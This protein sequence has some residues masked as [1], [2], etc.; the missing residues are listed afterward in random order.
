MSPLERGWSSRATPGERDWDQG[1]ESPS[2]PQVLVW[3]LHPS[4]SCSKDAPGAWCGFIPALSGFFGI[5][6]VTLQVL[7]KVWGQGFAPHANLEL[8]AKE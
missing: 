6:G 4:I 1:R 5:C 7:W 2:A 3:I 8:Y